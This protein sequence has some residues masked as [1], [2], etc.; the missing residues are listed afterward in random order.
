M[1]NSASSR[2]QLTYTILVYYSFFFRLFWNN[3][4]VEKLVVGQRN[5]HYKYKGFIFC[6]ESP[7]EPEYTSVLRR[8]PIKNKHWIFFGI[9]TVAWSCHPFRNMQIKSDS[10]KDQITLLPSARNYT[11]T[12]YF[13]F[14][15]KMKDRFGLTKVRQQAWFTTQQHFLED[16]TTPEMWREVDGTQLHR[17]NKTNLLLL[18]KWY[19]PVYI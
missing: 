8:N 9:L 11:K 15:L 6:I 4:Y 12:F 10:C 16:T 7:T 2:H 14:F 18:K 1:S 17:R 5:I 13:D 3:T 19:L